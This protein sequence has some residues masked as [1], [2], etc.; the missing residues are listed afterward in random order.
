LKAQ[1]IFTVNVA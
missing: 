1:N